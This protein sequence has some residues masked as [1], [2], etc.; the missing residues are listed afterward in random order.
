ML[1]HKAYSPIAQGIS[2]PLG[3]RRLSVG[4]MIETEASCAKLC[5]RYG[6]HR[7]LVETQVVGRSDDGDGG[8]RAFGSVVREAQNIGD[9]RDDDPTVLVAVVRSLVS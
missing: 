3:R 7:G 4:A 2:G 9:G 8:V 6:R 1:A 5:C